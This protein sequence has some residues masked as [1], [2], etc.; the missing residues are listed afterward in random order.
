MET[1]NDNRNAGGKILLLIIGGFAALFLVYYTVLSVMSPYRKLK[2]I[3][4]E[5]GSKKKEQADA[6]SA[7]RRD[8][9]YVG[10]LREKAFLQSKISMAETDSIY[11]TLDLPDSTANLEI[12]GVNVHTAK[13]RKIHVSRILRSGDETLIYSMLSTPLNIVKDYA[14]IKKEPLMVKMAPKDTTE[15]KPDIM[16]DTSDVQPVNYLLEMNNGIRIYV[17]QTEDTASGARNKR[18]RFELHERIKNAAAS[19]KSAFS[20]K[21]PEYHPFIKIELPKSDA[22][23]MYRAIPRNG[24]IAVYL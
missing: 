1:D 12:S 14:T 17:F 20:F 23:I 6:D 11:I 10:L 22:K 7:F 2:E 3:R 16:P 13:I 18:F 4:K 21:V 15:Y 8:S 9:L 19:L 5:Y 24:Q